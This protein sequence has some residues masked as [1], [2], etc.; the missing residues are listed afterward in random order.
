[1]DASP[2]ILSFLA[3]FAA[4][5]S[6]A[7]GYLQSRKRARL[8]K[9]LEQESS[10]RVAAEVASVAVSGGP[11]DLAALRRAQQQRDD[12]DF[13]S[14]ATKSVSIEAVS[15]RDAGLFQDGTWQ[16]QPGINVLLGRNGYCKSLLLR[17]LAALLS[18][19]EQQM[20][21]KSPSSR[22]S[23]AVRVGAT[24]Q[25]I[26]RGSAGFERSLGPVPVLAIPDSRFV[27]RSEDALRAA[28]DPYAKLARDGAYHFVEQLPYNTIVQGLL[29]SLC[30]DYFQNRESFDLPIFALLTEV[31]R[32]LTDS[33]FRFDSIKRVDATGFHLNV[34]TEGNPQ[35]VPVQV[36][37]QG[38]LSVLAVFGLIFRQLEGLARYDKSKTP[39]V[40]RRAIVIIDE[41]D[42]HLHPSWQQRI[43][44]LLR[45]HFPNIQFIISAHSPLLVAGAGRGET[46]V[47]RKQDKRFKIVTYIDRD[48]IGATAADIYGTIFD[49]AD[50]DDEVFLQHSKLA[51]AKVDNRPQ[52]ERLRSR[53]SLSNEEE[54]ELRRL[55]QE[56]L[57]MRRVQAIEQSRSEESKRLV[58][59]ETECSMLRIQVRKLQAEVTAAK[60]QPV[61]QGTA[62]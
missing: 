51:A 30:F 53:E 45:K 37:S 14:N 49:V 19:S 17:E 13:E 10:R 9:Q 1:M 11:V 48:F 42:A 2:E 46:S 40:Q 52:I 25:E 23:V 56:D 55:Q 44:G 60:A 43:G 21:G 5:A 57:Y 8:E 47:L 7:F 58:Q 62:R 34:I 31:F 39:L 3:L 12:A 18:R 59:L 20:L 28:P 22:L 4:I 29:H 27:N 36:A 38:T 6:A 33:S 54:A 15:F 50:G 16:L 61:E 35:P 24:T 32:E 26:V 41:L